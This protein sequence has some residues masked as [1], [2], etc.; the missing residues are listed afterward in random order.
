MS[1]LQEPHIS[2][3]GASRLSYTSLTSLLHEPHVSPTGAS[4]LSCRSLTSP[5]GASRSLNS[6]GVDSLHVDL[7]LRRLDHVV[8]EHGVEVRD[9]GGEHDA[10]RRELLIPDLRTDTASV[11]VCVCMCVC[12]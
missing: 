2:P 7:A 11:C 1:L 6:R 12:A 4:H 10:V 5:T 9:G 8:R 3:A